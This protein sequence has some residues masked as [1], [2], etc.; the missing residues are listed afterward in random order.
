MRRKLTADDGE[1]TYALDT[2]GR[3][4]V[5]PRAGTREPRERHLGTHRRKSSA[6]PVLCGVPSGECDRR[7]EEWPGSLASAGEIRAPSASLQ[8]P[9]LAGWLRAA[10]GR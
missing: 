1:E 4:N 8:R 5:R 10:R 3:E 9:G 2:N 6:H 7:L